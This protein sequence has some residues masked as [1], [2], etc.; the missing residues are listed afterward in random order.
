MHAFKRIAF[1]I[2][3]VATFLLFGLGVLFTIRSL[4]RGGNILESI[5][6]LVKFAWYLLITG[7]DFITIA[8]SIAVMTL[9][10]YSL[11][12]WSLFYFAQTEKE[13]ELIKL[14]IPCSL[15]A[16]ILCTIGISGAVL[17]GL[18]SQGA[19]Q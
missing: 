4:L 2:E 1:R 3:M 15:G 14:I 6:A 16:I 17:S 19:G 10:W 8:P 12:I 5:S 18:A 13:K 11:Y 9:F 7:I